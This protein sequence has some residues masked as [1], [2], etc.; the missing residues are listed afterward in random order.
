MAQNADDRDD[1][2]TPVA[3]GYYNKEE[4]PAQQ[5]MLQRAIPIILSVVLS[6]IVVMFWAG[7]N[8]V[9]QSD[10]AA[11]FALVIEDITG[12]KASSV[13]LTN[14]VDTM[15]SQMSQLNNQVAAAVK[16]VDDMQT[17]QSQY[18]KTSTI[19]SLNSSLNTIKNDITSLQSSLNT[20]KASIPDTSS[21]NS[22]IA[23]VQSSLDALK[24]QLATDEAAIKSL[25]T[26]VAALQ[27]PPTTTPPPTTTTTTPLPATAGMSASIV[28]SPTMS[29]VA[30]GSTINVSITNNSA[31]T[32]YAEQLSLQLQFLTPTT[33]I[34]TWGLTL[35]TTSGIVGSPS[36]SIAPVIVSYV[37][38]SSS[39]ITPGA[40]QTVGIILTATP[41]AYP[42]NFVATVVV[43]GYSALP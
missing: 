37:I 38:D 40:S 27:A 5:G 34:S 33:A 42:Q 17:S 29:L 2:V 3:P 41:P 43:T 30:T 8:L 18:A 36:Y 22:N 25:Q 10:E 14:K 32:V 39:Y 23:K 15:T 19:D 13:A 21:I 31:K 12:L 7:G 1:R 6:V 20:I 11:N 28:G 35:T 24:S 9:S 16:K 4:K 26:A